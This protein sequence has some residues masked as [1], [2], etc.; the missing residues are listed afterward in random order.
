MPKYDVVI[1]GSGLGGLL[2][3]TILSKEGKS[4]CILEKHHQLG[5]NLQTFKRDGKIFDTGFHYV[6]G[7]NEGQNLHQYFKYFGLTGKLRLERL[8]LNS[9]DKIGFKGKEYSFAQGFDRFVEILTNDFPSEKNAL[10]E[11]KKKIKEVCNHFPLYN[12]KPA[13]DISSEQKYLEQ[14]IG[15]FLNSVT[16]NKTLQNVLA[17]N[18]LLYA[19]T[20]DKSSLAMHAL[21]ANSFIDGG[22]YRFVDGSSQLTDQLVNIIEQNG[23]VLRKNS[24]AVNFTIE[25]DK[26][27]SVQLKNGEQIEGTQ[28]ISAIHPHATLQMVNSDL[29]RKSYR[30]RINELDETI[31][32]FILFVSFKPDSFKY[33][34]SNYYHFNEDTVWTISS[35]NPEKWPQNY[36]F[37]TPPSGNS[38]KFAETAT[39]ITYM[40]YEEVQ[41]WENTKSGNRGADYEEFKKQKAEKLIEQVELNHPGFKK[42]IHKYY[43]SSPLTY[44]DYTGTRN[45]SLYGI[46]HDCNNLLKTTIP[47][48]TKIPNLLFTGQNINLHGA[49]GVTV[50]SVMTCSEIL[51]MEYLIQKM[52]HA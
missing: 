5:G 51:G 48:K 29:I 6:G 45:G 18:N 30:E 27:K 33:L 13:H 46:V 25:N 16:S 49:L 37:L 35:Y 26:I 31:S 3:G 23:G 43:T 32:S 1:I 8:D 19:G 42:S 41:Q 12:L 21:I 15:S 50:G 40:K 22:A 20:P 9:F 52:N 11:Y 34:K 44:R 2:C 39:V 28:F 7:L 36:M 38:D 14:S 24:E 17:G 4:V 10:I 47:A